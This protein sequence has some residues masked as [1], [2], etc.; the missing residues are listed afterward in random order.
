MEKYRSGIVKFAREHVRE[1]R[2]LRFLDRHFADSLQEATDRRMQR[3][4]FLNAIANRAEGGKVAVVWSGMDCDCVRFSGVVSI[5]DADKASVE[6]HI[7]REYEYAEGPLSF[8][9]TKPSDAAKIHYESRDLA[10]E[11]FEDGHAHVVYG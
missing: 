8:Y 10:M 6:A 2:V 11:A 1:G 3:Q 9:I 5:V 7:E 4:G